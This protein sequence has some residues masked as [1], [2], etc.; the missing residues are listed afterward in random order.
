[1]DEKYYWPLVGVLIGWVLNTIS[2]HSKFRVEQKIHT[3]KALTYLMIIHDQL[4]Q[5]NKHLEK[6]KDLANSWEEYEPMRVSQLNKHF[7]ESDEM[8][9]NI[10]D[11]FIELAGVNPLLADKLITIKHTL[12]KL[13]SNKLL[14]SSK[15]QSVY[16]KLLSAQETVNELLEVKLKSEIK[17]LAF[18]YGLATWV[19]VQ[20]KY[21]K[22]NKATGAAPIFE[23]VFS[24]V[25]ELKAKN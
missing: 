4:S 10:D 14:E 25:K 5:M 2:N 18:N 23:D 8:L 6:L 11:A 12:V 17:W 22:R 7:L 24:E 9:K 3:G 20:L 16:I 13:R 15:I 21:I 19:R 1:M